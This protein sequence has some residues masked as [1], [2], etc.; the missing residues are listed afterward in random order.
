VVG[1]KKHSYS[2]YKKMLAK[3]IRFNQVSDLYGFRI[4]VDSVDTCYRALGVAHNLYK[5]VPGKFK[6][7][8]AIPKPN[9][10]QSLHTQL[11]GPNGLPLEIQIRTED[12]DYV[13]ANG[14]A[15]H[16]AYKESVDSLTT[17]SSTQ[18]WLQSLMEMQQQSGNSLEFLENVKVDLF[19]DN[20]YVFTPRGEIKILPRGS[21]L[22]D[23]A[24]AIHSD[25]GNSCVAGKVD[26][27]QVPLH[28]RLSSGQTVEVVAVEG[29]K[30]SAA[31]LNFVVTA[32]ARSAIR[33][34]LKNIRHHEAI[35]IGRRLLN[36][37]FAMEN[38]SLENLSEDVIQD[39]LEKRDM[40]GLSQLYDEIGMGNLMPALVARQILAGQMDVDQPAEQ[41]ASSAVHMVIEGGEDTVLHYAGCCRPIPGDVIA[42]VFSPGRGVVVHRRGC[43]NL[44][45]YRGH[46]SSWLEMSWADHPYKESFASEIRIEAGNQ[47]GVLARTATILAEMG[48][49]IE[50]VRSEDRDGLSSVLDFVISVRDRVELARI[51][52]RLYRQDFIFKVY[53]LR[54]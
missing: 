34:F 21:T 31:W 18:E 36:N 30:P 10:Y 14:I 17:R 48:C 25:V 5:P 29:A 12:M 4:I 9:G 46:H 16:W 1:R 50:N 52:R 27:R 13:A 42:G 3:G 44:T 33:A 22:L 43:H 54:H 8:I 39:Y 7:Y 23:F 37:A 20:V 49:N 38:A 35:D 41:K 26:W 11:F 28:T 51:M 19:P 47:R 53:R 40:S 2:I 6:D 45:E 32:K 15:A 24:Y